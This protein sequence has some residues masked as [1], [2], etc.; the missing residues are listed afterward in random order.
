VLGAN[1]LRLPANAV[2]ALVG[3]NGCG[4]STL[5]AAAANVAP[6]NVGRAQLVL[7]GALVMSVAYLPQQPLLPPGTRVADAARAYTVPHLRIETELAASGCAEL[8]ARD[9]DALSEGERRFVCATL[10]LARRLPV[11]L[12]DEPLA[13][14]DPRRRA[15]VLHQIARAR[16][17]PPHGTVI[18]AS[19]EVTE[20]HDV[21]DWVVALRN[22]A[23]AYS[24]RRDA[25]LPPISTASA[26]RFA[27][28]VGALIG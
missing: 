16:H 13:G 7:D 15:S 20:L 25:L 22:G 2:I 11:T 27:E 17:E 14:L 3:A 8:L 21:C 6:P 10:T 12:L 18:L 19:H 28:L 26:R 9:G 5:L 1:E 23:V 4:K 24:G